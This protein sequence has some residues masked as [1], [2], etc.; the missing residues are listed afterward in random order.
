M[1]DIEKISLLNFECYRFPK[2]MSGTT[3]PHM[4]WNRIGRQRIL[5]EIK[6]RLRL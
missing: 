1:I 5:K 6:A 2:Y 4:L 3:Q